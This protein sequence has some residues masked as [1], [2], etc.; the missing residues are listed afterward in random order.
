MRRRVVIA[1]I[2][3]SASAGAVWRYQSEVLGAGARWYLERVAA[4]ERASGDLGQRRETVS[5]LHRLLLMPAPPE[6]MVPELFDFITLLSSRVATGEVSLA[7]SAYLYT[8]YERDM[9]RDRPGGL[10]ARSTAEI[11]AALEE[12]IAFFQIRK[13]PDMAGV[14]VSDLFGTDGDSYSLEEIQ[15]AEREGREL[16]LR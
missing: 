8:S 5:R 10:P 3:L 1:L 11:A 12:Q 15:R 2:V 6:A 13:R 14:R 4:R 7:W 9:A 16:P